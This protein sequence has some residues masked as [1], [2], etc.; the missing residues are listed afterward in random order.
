MKKEKPT[1]HCI[2]AQTG[3]PVGELL[4]EAFRAYLCGMLRGKDCK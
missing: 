1:V 2:Y 3:K 4:E